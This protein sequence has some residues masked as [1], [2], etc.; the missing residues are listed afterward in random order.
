METNMDLPTPTESTPSLWRAFRQTAVRR[1]FLYRDAD[2]WLR[3]LN[4][5]W[6]LTEQRARVVEVVDE[7]PTAKTFVLEPTR[8]LENYRAG[9]YLTVEVEVDG[10]RVRRCYSISTP[11]ERNGTFTI[12]VKRV[13]D[14]RVSNRL[15]DHLSAG[16]VLTVSPAMGEFILPEPTPAALLFVTGGSG[17][18]PVMAMLLD[19]AARGDLADAVL[20]HYARSREDVI[21]RSRLEALAACHPGFRLVL[22]LD[23]DPRRADRFSEEE[24]R[25]IV[26]NFASRETFLCGPGGLMERIENMWRGHGLEAR[27]H[28]ER[29]VASAAPG[30]AD[31]GAT[32]ARVTLVRARRTF[33]SDGRSSLLEQ[34]ERAGA[35]PAYG[36]RMGIC[37]TCKCRKRSGAVQNV[38]TGEVSTEPD[39]DIQLCISVP[40][41]D[42]VIDV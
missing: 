8:R 5:A 14:G 6:S 20:V 30:F 31:A 35:R 26:P 33:V 16:D 40:R 24:L 28:Q 32:G 23:D 34:A 36:C 25:A 38:V 37:Q 15:H 12:T 39:E 27:L 9:Q 22:C 2:F 1:L 17:I 41:S 18:T 19:R 42:V 13:A 29:F 21:F 11:P 4:P 3:E 10:V 7:T